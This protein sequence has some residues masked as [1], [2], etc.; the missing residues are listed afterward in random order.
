M[1]SFMVCGPRRVGKTTVMQKALEGEVGVMYLQLDP[2]NVDNFYS[3][4]L[5]NV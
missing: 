1:S 5:D 4:V 2:R 3:S